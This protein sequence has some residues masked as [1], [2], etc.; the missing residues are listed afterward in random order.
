MHLIQLC[1]ITTSIN[2]ILWVDSCL[3]KTSLK[4]IQLCPEYSFLLFFFFISYHLWKGTVSPH[5]WDCLLFRKTSMVVQLVKNLLAVQETQVPSLGW[6]DPVEKEMANQFQ[7]FCLGNPMD[8]GNW[9]ATVHGVTKVG[10]NLATKPPPP[11]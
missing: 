5:I 2:E 11:I 4:V 8:R 9:W 6:G 7:Y 1:I 3:F 10:H